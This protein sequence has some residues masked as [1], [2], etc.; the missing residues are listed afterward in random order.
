MSLPSDSL[1]RFLPIYQKRVWG[2]RSLETRFHR[3][4]P[5]ASSPFGESWE[6]SARAEA[7]STVRGGSLAG[8]TLS[9]LWADRELRSHIFGPAAPDQERFPLLCKILDAREKLSI[10]VHPPQAIA[11]ELGGEPKTEMWYIA[12]AN[13]GSL[14]YIGLKRGVEKDDFEA[15]LKGGT[16][17]NC[18]HTIE[19]EA[20]QFITIPSGR[21]HAID[22]G[23]LI[24]EIQQNSD[25]T[26]RVYDWNRVGLD[27]QPRKLHIEESL[28]CIDFDDRE[29]EM[30]EADG[31]VISQCEHFQVEKQEL[32]SGKPLDSVRRGRFAIV[33][34]VRGA[35]QGTPDE[36]FRE[37]DFFVIPFGQN[38]TGL[39]AAETST[40]VLIT[41]WH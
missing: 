40:Q 3:K 4:L 39:A 12:H 19:P 29:P 30:D 9:Q 23:L 32:P 24:Y 14:L 20:G 18:L 27:G 36:I 31:D 6:I 33:T 5:D 21:L 10:Q 1:L 25:T 15:A 7:D 22:G 34:V 35:I 17:E 38:D 16:L 28:R 37:G 8:H 41:T 2:G 13:R 11:E 26:Y